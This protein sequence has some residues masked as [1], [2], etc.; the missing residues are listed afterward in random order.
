LKP[1]SH[2]QCNVLNS[3]GTEIKRFHPELTD[4]QLQVL[5]LLGVSASRFDAAS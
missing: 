4:L 5:K 3:N 1:F 2:L